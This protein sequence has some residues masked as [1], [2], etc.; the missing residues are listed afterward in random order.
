MEMVKLL[1]KKLQN[2]H[3]VAKYEWMSRNN[4]GGS[5]GQFIYLSLLEIIIMSNLY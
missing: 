5:Y 4:N 3:T 2:A 1:L